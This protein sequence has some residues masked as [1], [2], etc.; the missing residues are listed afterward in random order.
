MARLRVWKRL[1][2]GARCDDHPGSK[3]D[4]RFLAVAHGGYYIARIDAVVAKDYGTEAT[5]WKNIQKHI[6]TISDA[7][8]GG[9]ELMSAHSPALANYQE[10]SQADRF[11]NCFRGFF[12]VP[13]CS[14]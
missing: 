5:V 1:Q 9:I 14:T 6:Y 7:L 8:A 10:A 2:C 11:G 12:F 3:D 13:C 4:A